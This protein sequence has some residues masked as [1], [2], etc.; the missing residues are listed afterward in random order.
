[1]TLTSAESA[2]LEAVR[3]LERVRMAAIRSNDADAM[4]RILDDKFLFINADGRLYDKPD[5]IRSVRHRELT[6]SADL[7]L[8]ET[9]QRVDGD[10]VILAG[11]MLGHALLRGEQQVYHLRTMRVWRARE[12]G[13]R[14]LA[15][16]ASEHRREWA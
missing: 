11:M 7:E 9:D 16:Q 4:D 3:E 8:T 15:W 14:L 12:A 5:Y 10:L 1:M 2:T 13:W 6:Y